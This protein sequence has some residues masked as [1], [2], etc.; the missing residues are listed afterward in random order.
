MLNT[1]HSQ[2]IRWRLI[3]TVQQ[4]EKR[5]EN[6]PQTTLLNLFSHFW[7]LCYHVGRNVIIWDEMLASGANVTM[8]SKC[9]YVEALFRSLAKWPH[10]S[11]LNLLRK[12]L[13]RIVNLGSSRLNKHTSPFCGDFQYMYCTISKLRELPSIAQRD[14]R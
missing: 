2:R 10:A 4:T 8:W 7:S 5:G 3:F 6:F 14:R 11:V 13:G 1:L 9:Y 12:D